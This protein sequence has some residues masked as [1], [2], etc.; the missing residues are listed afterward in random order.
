MKPI[1]PGLFIDGQGKTAIITYGYWLDLTELTQKEF[2]NYYNVSPWTSDCERGCGINKTV[3]VATYPPN[4]YDI[5]NLAGNVSESCW[6][7]DGGARINNRTNYAGPSIGVYK[8][9]RGGP[10][11]G[12]ISSTLSSSRACTGPAYRFMDFGFRSVLPAK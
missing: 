7:W 1:F 11:E 6:D 8:C 10:W 2:L 4:P 5:Y 3:N 12:G 9:R